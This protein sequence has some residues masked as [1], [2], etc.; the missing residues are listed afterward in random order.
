[1]DILKRIYSKDN[2]VLLGKDSATLTNITPREH[3][4]TVTT[5]LIRTSPKLPVNAPSINSSVLASCK[6]KKHIF[7]IVYDTNYTT[8]HEHAQAHA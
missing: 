1:M 4:L 8:V 5:Y 6:N 3:N 2:L 7:T